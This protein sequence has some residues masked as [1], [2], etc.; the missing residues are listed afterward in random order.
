MQEIKTMNLKFDT[1][2]IQQIMKQMQDNV[3]VNQ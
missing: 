1:K 2:E 3:E